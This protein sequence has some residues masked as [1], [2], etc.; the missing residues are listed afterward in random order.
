MR[1][2]MVRSEGSYDQKDVEM[3]MQGQ[4]QLVDLLNREW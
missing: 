2:W 3:D 4:E 1:G